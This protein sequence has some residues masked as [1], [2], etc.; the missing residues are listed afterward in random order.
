VIGRS[1][2]ARLVT[3]LALGIA[4][5]SLLSLEL[6]AQ[7]LVGVGAVPGPL[8]SPVTGDVSRREVTPLNDARQEVWKM[9]VTELRK[10][11]FSDQ[12]LPRAGDLDMPMTLPS[13][14]GEKPGQ[15]LRVASV[16]WDD[17][18]RRTQFRLECSASGECL[19]F[20]VYLRSEIP[21]EVP[22]EVLGSTDRH[23]EAW[24][25]SCR[26][27]SSH[28]APV[29]SA[30]LDVRQGDR[31]TAVFVTTRLRMTASV[32]CLERGRE[33]EVIRVRAADGHVFRARVSGPNRLEALPQ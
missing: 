31:A 17:G 1:I 3:V 16:C 13:L 12:Q 7:A 6:S 15:K 28:P 18:P 25:E 19:P 33:G 2:F 23:P 24:F 32:T 5:S 29:D 20:L 11:G 30:R 27:P 22:S 8:L 26:L 9:V 10:K 4:A 21:A 14:A